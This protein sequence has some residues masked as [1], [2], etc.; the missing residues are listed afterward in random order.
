M[1]TTGVTAAITEIMRGKNKKALDEFLN[2]SILQINK[3][4][5][6]VRGELTFHQRTLMGALS[7]IDVHARE[8]VRNM[9]TARVETMN[10]FEWMKQLR[11]YW[12]VLSEE[13]EDC[14]A[15]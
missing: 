9:I 3:M 15:K 12:E 2:F 1:W 14:F 5:D 13:D 8:V 11:Y 7:V 6:L 10:D 4:V